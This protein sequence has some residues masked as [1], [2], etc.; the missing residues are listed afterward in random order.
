MSSCPQCHQAIS[1]QTVIC[2]YCGLELK[3]H[4]HP[5]IDLHR[6]QLGT[7]LCDSCSY[8]QDD[9][10]TFPQRPQANTCTLYQDVTLAQEPQLSASEIYTIPWW[11]KYSGWLLLG[12]IVLISLALVIL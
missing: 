10:C 6:A 11:R 12:V 3:A 1:P 9:S 5:G 7:F 8:H 4:G 2:S